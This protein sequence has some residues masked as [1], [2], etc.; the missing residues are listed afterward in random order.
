MGK[1]KCKGKGMG[2]GK[3][4]GKGKVSV[5]YRASEYKVRI[6]NNVNI[7]TKNFLN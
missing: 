1:C 5:N 3:G 7:K 2:K 4:K 6:A